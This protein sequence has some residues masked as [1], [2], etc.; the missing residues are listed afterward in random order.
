MRRM[1][2]QSKTPLVLVDDNLKM[3]SMMKK[4]NCKDPDGHDVET[5]S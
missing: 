2:E 3:M 5:S 4:G 1:K